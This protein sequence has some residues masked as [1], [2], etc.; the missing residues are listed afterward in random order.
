MNWRGSFTILL[1]LCWLL[2]AGA[3]AKWLWEKFR[4][5]DKTRSSPVALAGALFAGAALAACPWQFP[6]KWALLVSALLLDVG[7][8]P[9]IVLS[10]VAFL[11]ENFAISREPGRTAGL[12]VIEKPVARASWIIK[13]GAGF[14]IWYFL[15]AGALSEPGAWG[16]LLIIL[17]FVYWPL[18][19]AWFWRL[20]KYPPPQ[21]KP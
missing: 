15:V 17:V 4:K 5:R 1:G 6:R 19:L 3:N 2:V 20:R 14:F 13:L 16:W 9:L 11:R 12:S 7:S 10:V 18:L 21:R 8:G